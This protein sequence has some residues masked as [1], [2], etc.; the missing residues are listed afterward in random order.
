MPLSSGCSCRAGSCLAVWD[1][2]DLPTPGCSPGACSWEL[3]CVHCGLLSFCPLPKVL[4]EPEP[5]QSSPWLVSS[6]SRCRLDWVMPWAGKDTPRMGNLFSNVGRKG[7]WAAFLGLG[8]VSLACDGVQHLRSNTAFTLLWSKKPPNSWVMKVSDIS[9]QDW[10]HESPAWE[11]WKCLPWTQDH[12]GGCSSR[13]GFVQRP[14]S[15]MGWRHLSK[16]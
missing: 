5:H 13:V 15:L 14:W 8:P 16:N 7:K 6:E 4:G 3:T 1:C 10:G 11:S 12:S 9:L 2:K